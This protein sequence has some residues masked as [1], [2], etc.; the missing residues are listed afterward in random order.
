VS[1][2]SELEAKPGDDIRTRYRQLLAW[3]DAQK[4]ITTDPRVHIHQTANGQHVHM[5][6]PSP[7]V[8]LPLQVRLAG[9][10]FFNVS[11]GYINGRLPKIQPSSGDLQEIVDPDGKTA[12]PAKLPPGRPLLFVARVVFNADLSFKEAVIET[13]EPTQVPRTGSA[14]YSVTGSTITGKVPLAFIRK[15]TVIPFVMHN[16]QVRAYGSAGNYRVI[17]WP[18]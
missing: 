16:L 10:K 13:A 4:L 11:E 3:I 1:V 18:A 9:T 5:T 17:Y 15:T 14:D 2:P 8:T 6:Q 12:P 7:T